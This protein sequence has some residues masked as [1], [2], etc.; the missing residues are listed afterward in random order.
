MQAT[1]LQE[2]LLGREQVT[3]HWSYTSTGPFHSQFGVSSALLEVPCQVF[4]VF[5][6]QRRDWLKPQLW[7]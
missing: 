3:D 1:T 4:W 7:P 6:T 5:S 2:K